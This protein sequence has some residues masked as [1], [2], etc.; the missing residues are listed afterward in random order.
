MSNRS[1][2][3]ES[4]VDAEQETANI[5]SSRDNTSKKQFVTAAPGAL[6]HSAY[7]RLWSQIHNINYSSLEKTSE[8]YSKWCSD[9]KHACVR[10]G[11]KDQDV[12]STVSGSVQVDNPIAPSAESLKRSEPPKQVN[13]LQVKKKKKVV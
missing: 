6:P 9:L 2:P 12:D 8:G 7:I 3:I 4:P 10:T 11:A 1:A 13:T 5:A